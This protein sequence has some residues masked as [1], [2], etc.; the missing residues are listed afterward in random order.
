MLVA[1]VVLVLAAIINGFFLGMSGLHPMQRPSAGAGPGLI[2]LLL[3]YDL[4]L[5]AVILAWRAAGW[6]ASAICFLVCSSPRLS[7]EA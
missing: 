7:S 3:S 2:G 1:K 5:L 4:L 6:L